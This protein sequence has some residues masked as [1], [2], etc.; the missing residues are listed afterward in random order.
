MLQIR[1]LVSISALS[2]DIDRISLPFFNEILHYNL[3][4]WSILTCP[5]ADSETNMKQIVV[6]TGVRIPI[7]DAKVFHTWRRGVGPSG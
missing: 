1:F 6:S 5:L 4:T 3:E 7:F 2:N